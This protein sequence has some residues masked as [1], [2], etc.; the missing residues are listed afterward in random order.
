VRTQTRITREDLDADM[1]S[2]NLYKTSREMAAKVWSI[3]ALPLLTTRVYP[4]SRR[5]PE[6]LGV[7][8]MD[9][10]QADFFADAAQLGTVSKICESF[11]STLSEVSGTNAGRLANTEFWGRGAEAVVEAPPAAEGSW[12]TLELVEGFAPTTGDAKQLNIDFSDFR[13]VE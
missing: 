2:L 11:L 9:S 1:R 8:Y 12:L 3:A 10:Y 6:V 13:P 4:G 7:L 5:S